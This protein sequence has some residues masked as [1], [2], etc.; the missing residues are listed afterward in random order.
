MRKYYTVW[1]TKELEHYKFE[2]IYSNVEIDKKNDAIKYAEQN[3]KFYNDA[4]VYL[5]TEKERKIFYRMIEVIE[6]NK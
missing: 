6:N 3:L 5:V 1:F 4:T 2:T